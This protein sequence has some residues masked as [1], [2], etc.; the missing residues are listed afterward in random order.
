[1]RWMVTGLI[2]GVVAFQIGYLRGYKA[3]QLDSLPTQAEIQEALGLEPDGVI[4]V[5]SRKVWDEAIERRKTDEWI[6]PIM[7]SFNREFNKKYGIGD[8]QT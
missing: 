1:M 3:G 2:A 7:E 8:N 5:E 4:G 6:M